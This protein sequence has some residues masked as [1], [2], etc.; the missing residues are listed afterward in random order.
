MKNI[1]YT[2]VFISK[3][4]PHTISSHKSITYLLKKHKLFEINNLRVHKY[5]YDTYF[6]N[7]YNYNLI[8]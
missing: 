2:H 4:I 7:F 1:K 8:L 5:L 6:Y 3:N